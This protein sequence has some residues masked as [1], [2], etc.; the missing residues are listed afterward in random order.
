MGRIRNGPTSMKIEHWRCHAQYPGEQLVYR[1]LLGACRGGEGQPLQRQHCD[2]RKGDRDILWNPAEPGHHI[3]TRIR[4]ELDGT[5]AGDDPVF[6]GHLNEVLNLNHAR[7]KN[8]RKGVLNGL[9]DWWRAEKPVPKARIEGEIAKRAN[10]GG[11]LAPYC[12]VA[13]WWLNQKLAA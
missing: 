12:L 7:I 8:N 11:D 10:P 3:E 2:T 5:I 13:V 1:N 4:Y 9:L 6:D